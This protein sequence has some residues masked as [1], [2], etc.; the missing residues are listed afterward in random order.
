MHVVVCKEFAW[1]WFSYF[2]IWA[3]RFELRSS[4]LV[5]DRWTYL[6]NRLTGSESLTWGS[7]WNKQRHP[8]INFPFLKACITFYRCGGINLC[9]STKRNQ[10]LKKIH[11]NNIIGIKSYRERRKKQIYGPK[12]AAE[13]R[14]SHSHSPQ[15]PKLLINTWSQLSQF[16]ASEP[17]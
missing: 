8:A 9:I 16:L 1:I 11:E 5:A 12:E 17:G 6:Q 13:N 7:R 2:T 14:P 10:L 15:H 4:G 3:L